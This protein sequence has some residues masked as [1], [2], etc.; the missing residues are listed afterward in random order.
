MWRHKPKYFKPQYL[1]KLA[2]FSRKNY[3]HVQYN[4]LDILAHNPGIFDNFFF[5]GGTFNIFIFSFIYPFAN[6]NPHWK[7]KF[8]SMHTSDQ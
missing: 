5:Q 4:F 2:I 6:G 3:K 7:A 1:A 8:H